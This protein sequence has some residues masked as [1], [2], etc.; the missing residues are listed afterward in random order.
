MRKQDKSGLKLLNSK[1]ARSDAWSR[2]IPTQNNTNEMGSKA[3]QIQ[4]Q[5]HGRTR[6]I[7]FYFIIIILI[8]F[9]Y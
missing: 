4:H 1:S 9:R 6:N 8:S 2:H 5:N 3:Y 7:Q